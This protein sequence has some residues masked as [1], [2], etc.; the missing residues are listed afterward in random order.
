M[1]YRLAAS[2]LCSSR[3]TRLYSYL[4]SSLVKEVARHGGD[5]KGLVPDFVIPQ[6][7][8]RLPARQTSATKG[9]RRARGRP[10]QLRRARRPRRGRPLDADV[11]VLRGQ[12]GRGARSARRAPRRSSPEEIDQAEEVLRR[13]EAVVESGRDE[14]AT[15]VAEAHEERMRLVSQTEVYAQAQ[16]EAAGSAPRRRSRPGRRRDETDAYVD[17]KLATFEISLNKTLTAVIRGRE[18]LRDE[19]AGRPGRTSAPSRE[20]DGCAR[21]GLGRPP[22]ARLPWAV[23][24]V[25]G[26]VRRVSA[27]YPRGRVQSPDACEGPAVTASTRAPPSCSTP[28]T[29][30]A[31]PDR[32]SRSPEPCRRRRAS[33]STSS[34]SPKASPLEL[35]S[36]WSRSSRACSCRGRPGRGSPGSACAAWSRLVDVRGRDVPG[37]VRLPGG[38]AHGTHPRITCVGGRATEPRTTRTNGSRTTS[39]TSSRCCGTRWCSHCRSS[40]CA[41]TTARGCAPSAEPAGGRPGAPARPADRPAVGRPAGPDRPARARCRSA[42]RPR[43]KRA[44]RGRPEAEDLALQHPFAPRQ[45]EG[46]RRSR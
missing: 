9:A 27:R 15:I 3:R 40:R 42:R 35:D 32:C 4:S 22:R 8:D 43:R 17:G 29:S 6:L 1:N 25:R 7:T 44:D 20:P 10:R 37:A 16:H 14:A 12:P 11:L 24:L 34:G 39:S 2:R 5:V 45:L 18:R 23:G 41:G 33:A 13:R 28:G 38:P 31:G 36:G 19:H 46:A 26:R 30:A 21:G